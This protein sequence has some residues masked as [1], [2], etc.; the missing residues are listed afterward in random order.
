MANTAAYQAAVA[1]LRARNDAAPAAKVIAYFRTSADA[2]PQDDQRAAGMRRL[3]SQLE[4]MTAWSKGER[5]RA[6]TILRE[7][8]PTEPNNASLPPTVIPSYELLGEFLLAMDRKSEAA[9]AFG[10]VLELRAN[11]AAAVRGMERAR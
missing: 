11:R 2:L 3:A 1:A 9:E 8:A 10:K 7:V 6:I 4:A 5:E